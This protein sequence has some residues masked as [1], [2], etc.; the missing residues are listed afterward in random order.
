MRA[1]G[2]EPGRRDAYGIV[3]IE[4]YSERSMNSPSAID[5]S[6]G[7]IVVNHVRYTM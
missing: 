6:A 3:V 4:L 7:P 2:C 5:G 1:V